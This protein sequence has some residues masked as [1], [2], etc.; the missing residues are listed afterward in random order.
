MSTVATDLWFLPILALILAV[1]SLLF[2][3]LS[4]LF[5]ARRERRLSDVSYVSAGICMVIVALI[6]M[7]A[8]KTIVALLAGVTVL[9][10]LVYPVRDWW[11]RRHPQPQK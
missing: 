7:R 4:V 10:H 6:S 2:F 11:H 1:S 9:L 8:G 3:A 5:W